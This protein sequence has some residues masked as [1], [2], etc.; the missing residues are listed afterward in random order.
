ML[1]DKTD[2]F[3]FVGSLA[4]L[5]LHITFLMILQIQCYIKVRKLSNII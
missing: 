5:R 4:E 2:L 1:G 3:N